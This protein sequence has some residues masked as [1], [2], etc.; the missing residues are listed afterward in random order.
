MSRQDF[1]LL[2]LLVMNFFRLAIEPI[3]IFPAPLARKRGVIY[4]LQFK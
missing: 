1:F 3:A 2:S 4:F